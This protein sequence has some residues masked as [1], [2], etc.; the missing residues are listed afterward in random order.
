MLIRSTAFVL[1][2]TV[3]TGFASADEVE[4]RKAAMNQIRIGAVTLVPMIKGEKPFDANLAELA[5]R[6][7][8][9]GALA[10]E[11]R[12]PEGST[13]KGANP[14]IWKKKDDFDAKVVDFIADTKAAVGALPKDL[15]ALKSVY[16]PIL[17]D[18]AACHKPYRIKDL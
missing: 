11:R 18:C 5:L 13:S 14:D 6:M 8:Y 17:E 3:A 1:G 2:L 12:F 4:K 10:F 7:T 16:Q 9:A 15:D